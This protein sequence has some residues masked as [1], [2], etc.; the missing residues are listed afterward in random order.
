MAT[1]KKITELTAILGA[2]LAS[3]D[4]FAVVDIDADETK[5]IT[6]AELSSV[7]GS[8]SQLTDLSDVSAKTGSGTTVVMSGSPTITTPTI[9][10]F[11]NA[12]HDHADAAGGGQLALAAL[13]DHNVA[14]HNALNITSLG[15]ITVGVWQGTVIDHER[16]GLEAD[17]SAYAGLVKISGGTTSQVTD[18][19]SNWNTAFTHTSNTSNP[20]SV[21]KAQVGLTNVEDTALSTW[22]GSANITTLGTITSGIW[23]GTAIEGTAIASTGEGGGSK[24]LRE[25]GDGTCS[26]IAIPGGGD[27][28][29]ANPLSQFASTTS[30]QLFGVMSDP[31]GTGALVFATSPTLV[32]PVLGTPASG[33]LTN[34]TAYEGTAILSTGEGGGTKF[35]R[36][37]GDGTC[38][39]QVG[40]GGATQLS[41][42]SDVSG[43]SGAGSTVFLGTVSAPADNE[44]VA[45]DNGT[46][47]WINQTAAEAG[48][49]TASDLSTHESDTTAIHG[50]ADTSVIA[51]TTDDL[52]V[53]ASTTSLQ[54]LNLISD[55]TGSGALVFATSPALTTPN[56]GTPSAGTLTSCT[57]LPIST[58]VSGLA[59]NVS[60][61]LATPS[62]ANLISAVTDET[63]S[64]LL[65]FATSP[66]LITPNIGTPSAGTL[67]NCT[68]LPISSG[69]S[70]LGANVAA[71]LATPSSVNLATAV[72]GETGSGALVFATSPILVT[73][74]LGTPTSGDLS[75]CT[76]YPGT[77]ALVTVGTITSG[78]WTGDTIA[79]ANGGTG[80]TTQ[81][82]AFDALA[83]TTTK[84]DIIVSN[85]SDNIRLA[86]GTNDQVLIADS[87]QASGVKWGA[88]PGGGA[89]AGTAGE[90]QMS[91]GASG[92]SDDETTATITVNG[93]IAITFNGTKVD[94]DD[95]IE[96]D[97]HVYQT[98][99]PANTVSANA[100][101]ID[102]GVGNSQQLSLAASTGSTAITLTAPDG[103]CHLTL[104]ITQHASS[105]VAVTWPA[106]VKWPGGTAPTITATNSAVDVITFLYDGTNYYGNYSQNF[107]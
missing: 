27:A 41:D 69:V 106:T 77:A 18:N 65:V 81:T 55:E 10:S 39:W 100:V 102:W 75:N 21:T 5:K 62:S 72:T 80:Q 87:V 15:T 45:Y 66:V 46:S 97:G 20:H 56:I 71:F 59:A 42:L 63:G 105:P 91:D 70:G 44:L 53:F 37:D 2:A 33:N 13:S 7:I 104:K 23:N 67:T 83:P 38:S 64:G 99:L 51:L 40:G 9:A 3:T 101:T 1:D 54:L 86:V 28:L 35:L 50:I 30:L 29:V 58:G 52:S 92:F 47:N 6:Y 82:A 90:I 73:P 4:V 32:T 84:G 14:A 8:V 95:D 24:F 74:T 12:Q 31:T 89:A 22:A 68:G 93:G 48:L 57:G 17:V 85:G 78:T 107:S 79:I 26:W 60:T 94:F 36:E 43:T 61:F 88:A 11:S 76:G 96:F 19:S 103:P 98:D 34:C 16:G 25:D 49:A